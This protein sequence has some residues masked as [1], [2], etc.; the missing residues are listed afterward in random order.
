MESKPKMAEFIV[1]IIYI[2]TV[3]SN[4]VSLWKDGRTLSQKKKFIRTYYPTLYKAIY[5]EGE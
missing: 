1:G 4:L 3:W 2:K 5:E